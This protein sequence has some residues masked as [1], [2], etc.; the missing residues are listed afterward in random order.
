MT[1][2][3]NRAA[4]Q[5][6]SKKIWRDKQIL[7]I[8]EDLNALEDTARDNWNT[9]GYINRDVLYLAHDYIKSHLNQRDKRV[10]ALKHRIQEI[11]NLLD[12][13]ASFSGCLR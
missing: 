13:R 12:E 8:Q 10:A 11:D 1:I 7:R 2:K 4:N 5:V 9:V 6:I 3:L